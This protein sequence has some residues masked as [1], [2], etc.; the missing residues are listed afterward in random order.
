MPLRTN[1]LAG[2]AATLGL[3]DIQPV[4]NA[5]LTMQRYTLEAKQRRSWARPFRSELYI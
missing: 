5:A 1:G 2:I 3:T 4:W